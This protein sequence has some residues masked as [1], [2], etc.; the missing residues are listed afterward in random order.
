MVYFFLVS[1]I[2]LYDVDKATD[3]NIQHLI[4]WILDCYADACKLILCCEDDSEIVDSVKNRCKVIE[5]NA[6]ITHE[7]YASPRM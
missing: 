4:K 1:V 7:V 3:N 2:V 5:V 6:P